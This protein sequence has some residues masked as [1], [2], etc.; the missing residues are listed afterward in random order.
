MAGL[1]AAHRLDAAHEVV[2]LEADERPGGHVNTV[3][4]DL[5][6]GP[7]AVDT[8]FIVFN[9][10]NYPFLTALL[11]ELGVASQPGSMSFS[12][13][14]TRLGLEYRP[15]SLIG[16][17]AQPRNLVSLRFHRMLWEIVRFNRGARELLASAQASTGDVPATLTL[18]QFVDGLGLSADFREQF[19]IPFGSSI[20]SAD[21]ARF[22]EFPALTYIRFMNNHHLL[23]VS[24][25]RQ[26]RTV[27]GGSRTYVDELLRRFSGGLRLGDPVHAVRRTP[28]GVEVA[29]GSDPAERFDRVILATHS[30]QALALLDEPTPAEREL[31]GA[32]AFQP[33]R[34]T[35]H[36][37]ARLMPKAR[38]VWAS[39]NYRVPPEPA[40]RAT[41]TYWMNRLQAIE[42]PQPLL[43]SLNSDEQ[44]APDKVIAGFDSRHPVYDGPSVEARERLPEIQGTGGVYFAGAWTGDG[45]HE[46]GARSG[47][48]VA[49][50]VEAEADLLPET[51]AIGAAP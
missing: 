9:E 10:P 3:T 49:A 11:E 36:T 48:E 47:A 29:S 30:D 22:L 31:L 45:F 37:D 35:L 25:H 2:L 40:G 43:V 14:D 32:I 6:A 34:V 27:A 21:P 50:L 38:Q 17:F 8:G 20:W 12:V 42:S 15:A 26:W 16:S 46:D 4:V 23:G 28:N 51:E 39:W 33:N 44:I 19:L 7:V 13:S 1:I 18:R 5:P 24:G 41:L